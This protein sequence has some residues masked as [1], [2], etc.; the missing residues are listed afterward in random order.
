MSVKRTLDFESTTPL[1]SPMKKSTMSSPTA[2]VKVDSSFTGESFQSSTLLSPSKVTE[3]ATKVDLSAMLMS[4][5]PMQKKHF[6]GELVDES[7]SWGLTP[8]NERVQ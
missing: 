2:A 3:P 7:K 5:S 4:L 1:G 6:V 8:I